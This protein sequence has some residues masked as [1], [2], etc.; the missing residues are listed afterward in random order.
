MLKSSEIIWNQLN[1]QDIDRTSPISQCTERLNHVEPVACP[2][3]KWPV[4]PSSEAFHQHVCR[5]SSRQDWGFRMANK[6]DKCD[7]SSGDKVPVTTGERWNIAAR[8]KRQKPQHFAKRLRSHRSTL[9]CA[10]QQLPCTIEPWAGSH[11]K[12]ATGSYVASWWWWWS[13]SSSA[14]NGHHGKHHKS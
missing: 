14:L 11:P 4:G 10:Q 13:S 2:S 9:I 8:G 6:C 1:R 5:H 12:S 7:T 3:M